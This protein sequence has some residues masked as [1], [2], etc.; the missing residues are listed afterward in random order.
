MNNEQSIPSEN[1]NSISVLPT[2]NTGTSNKTVYKADL[3]VYFYTDS[4][5]GEV[6]ICTWKEKIIFKNRMNT[7]QL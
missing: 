6:K 2:E 7:H 4:Y 5:N 1:T 3:S